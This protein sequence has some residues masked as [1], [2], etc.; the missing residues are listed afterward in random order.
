[1]SL[2]CQVEIVNSSFENGKQIVP[3]VP[4]C[5]STLKIKITNQE[6]EFMNVAIYPMNSYNTDDYCGGY[7]DH[8]KGIKVIWGGGIEKG[9]RTDLNPDQSK[10]LYL[11]LYHFDKLISNHDLTLKVEKKTALESDLEE[12][13]VQL[14]PL[15]NLINVIKASSDRQGGLMFEGSAILNYYPRWF[16]ESYAKIHSTLIDE[17]VINPNFRIEIHNIG[18]KDSVIIKFDDSVIATVSGDMDG[19]DYHYELYRLDNNI[20]VIRLWFFWLNR[21]NFKNKNNLSPMR[22]SE[23]GLFDWFSNPEL[24]DFERFD[25]VVGADKRV[26]FVGTDFHWQEY[27]YAIDKGTAQIDASIVKY[28]FPIGETIERLILRMGGAINNASQRDYGPIFINLLNRS[29][30]PA[31]YEPNE[32]FQNNIFGRNYDKSKEPIMRGQNFL[33]SHVPYVGA[34]KIV[35]EMITQDMTTSD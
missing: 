11:S 5:I 1:L 15:H 32:V 25:L 34:G 21:N 3:F 14:I 12:I 19:S 22:S 18:E 10:F 31:L 4:Y 8:K 16:P 9:V 6:A 20:Y 13:T 29:K 7:D 27:W 30:A 26:L 24:P 28:V 33:R 23:R 2:K 17:N 35:Y